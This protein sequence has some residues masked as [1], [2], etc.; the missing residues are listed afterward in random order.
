MIKIVLVDIDEEGKNK[1][2]NLI[3]SQKDLVI[4]GTGKD[5]YDAIMLVKKFQPD[6]MLLD[7]SLGIADGVEICCT[8]KRYSPST[9]IVI[10]SSRVE[11]SLIQEM[12]K[13]KITGCLLIGKDMDRLAGILRRIHQGECYV[14]SQITARAFQIL[15]EFFR[16][17][18]SESQIPN[19]K[20]QSLPKGFSKTE[21]K[22]LHLIAEGQSSKE[23]AQTLCIKDG[24]VRNYIS[25]VMQKAG[26]KNRTQIALYALQN[27]FG[28]KNYRFPP[29]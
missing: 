4:Q 23:I 7:A 16:G 26:L 6:I 9:E 27:G 25:S 19:G 18:V 3:S 28:K 10:Y 24:T 11:D 21:L 5:N 20:Q 15:A 12:V 17:K 14:N 29:M 1:I 13:G 8:L 22:L 2:T